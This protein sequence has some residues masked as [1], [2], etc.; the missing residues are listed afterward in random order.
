MSDHGTRARYKRGCRCVRCNDANTAHGAR[1]RANAKARSAEQAALVPH[2]EI[3]GYTYWGCRC[4]KC[5][6]ARRSYDRAYRQQQRAE[7]QVA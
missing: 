7:S 6:R 4:E 2:G 1:M 5:G 3:S